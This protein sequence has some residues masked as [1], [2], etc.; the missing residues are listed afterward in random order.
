MSAKLFNRALM[1]GGEQRNVGASGT[2]VRVIEYDVKDHIYRCEGAS[3]PTDGDAGYSVGCIFMLTSGGIGTTSYVND[4]SVTSCDFNAAIGGTGDIT[5]VVAGAGL[6]GGGATG[7]VTLNV[8]N[9]DG[10]ITVGADTIDI[11]AGSLVNADI[12]AAAA[13]AGS[14]LATAGVTRLQLSVPAGSQSAQK[15]GATITTTGAITEYM[16]APQTG[17]LVSAEI[18]PLVALTA[19]DTN[20]ITWTIVNL[21]QAGSDTTAMLAVANANTTKATGGTGL[22]INT[23]RALTVHGTPAN[24]A[25]VAGDKIAI[26][27][28]ASGTLANTVTLPL[29]ILRFGGTT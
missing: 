9:T 15:T 3:V 20:Y 2:S 17:S 11:A 4:G 1:I 18:N 22:G 6:T 29:Y 5:S 26:T 27:A 12:N 8:V 14:K 21:G 19:D 23:K 25:V 7:A 16:V 10:K 24:L 13:I 28:T